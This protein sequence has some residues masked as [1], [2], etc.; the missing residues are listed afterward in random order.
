MLKSLSWIIVLL[1][2]TPV[3]ANIKYHIEI[4]NANQ[5][6]AKISNT[7][8]IANGQ[9]QLLVKMPVWRTGRYEVLNFSSAISD[10]T[11]V[12]QDN[13]SLSFEKKDKSTWLIVPEKKTK[14]VTLTYELYA[15]E[16][17]L[18]T[19]HID[20][21]HGFFDASATFLYNDKSRD[22]EITI[23]W[24]GPSSWRGRSGLESAGER[25]F[26]AKDFDELI[27]SPIEI[28]VHDFFSFKEGKTFEVMIWGEG[29]YDKKQITRDL[30]KIVRGTKEI[31]G[32]YPFERYLFMLHLTDGQFGATEHVNSTIIDLDRHIFQDRE[33]YLRFVRVATHEFIHTWNVKAYRPQ[34]IARYNYDKE[35]YSKLLWLSEGST[36]YYEDLI[37]LKAGVI[38]QKEFLKDLAQ[39]L[40][41]YQEKPGNTKV[42]LADYSFDYWMKTDD[43]HRHHNRSSGIYLEGKILSL[44]LDLLMLESSSGKKGYAE[45]H[46]SL[47]KDYRLPKTFDERTIKTLLK[48]HSTLKVDELWQ[49]YVDGTEKLPVKEIMAKLGLELNYGGKTAN[50]AKKTAWLGIEIKKGSNWVKIERV[51]AGSP[52]WEAG[53]TAGDYISAINGFRV[54][55]KSWQQRLKTLKVLDKT[56][57]DYFRRGKAAKT[58]A[59]ITAKPKDKW[60]LK[61]VKKPTKAQKRLY[62]AWTR[63]PWPSKTKTTKS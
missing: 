51:T 45:V 31:W 43:N 24:D 26:K 59:K 9:K 62:E 38:T 52:A 33:Q 60:A 16:L 12:D 17:N 25:A 46:K 20:D 58:T 23:T 5:H 54:D 21:T 56:E 27:D 30:Q 63:M 13:Q 19:R 44:Y 37:L 2:S 11:A 7:F 35:N 4:T 28:G 61:F 10:F 8:P 47:F 50:E 41:A 32:S 1:I 6:L 22:Q 48:K 18:R 53:L 40:Q 39:D 3:S 14:S 36:S 15:N 57:I 55:S 49:K 29:N 34:G 42:S